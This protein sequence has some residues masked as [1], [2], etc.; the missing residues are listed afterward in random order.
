MVT[1]PCGLHDRVKK[2][3]FAAVQVFF[4]HRKNAVHQIQESGFVPRLFHSLGSY[5][6]LLFLLCLLRCGFIPEIAEA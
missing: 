1:A 6:C 5:H 2:L 3:R 4:R